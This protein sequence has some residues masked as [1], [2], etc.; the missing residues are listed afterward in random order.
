MRRAVPEHA[1]GDGALLAM[2]H[3]IMFALIAG[4]FGAAI[5]AVAYHRI[6]AERRRRRHLRFLDRINREFR[7]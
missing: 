5:F 3:W 7:N 4:A 6:E 1:S 2:S